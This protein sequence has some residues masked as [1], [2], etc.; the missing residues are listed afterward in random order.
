[1]R[2]AM[3]WILLFGVGAGEVAKPLWLIVGASD[4]SP[5]GIA[6]K[7]K[8]AAKGRAAGL[9]FDARDCGDP[10]AVYGWAVELAESESAAHEAL[11]R[12]RAGIP[13]AYVKRCLVRP[14]SLLSV[15]QAAVDGSI[16]GVP[17]DVVNWSDEQR[18]SAAAAVTVGRVVVVVR[19]YVSYPNDEMEGRRERLVVVGPDSRSTTLLDPCSGAGSVG[20]RGERV[21]FHCATEQAADQDL[22]TTYVFDVAGK[23][24]AAIPRCG[25]PHW[26]NDR[27]VECAAESIGS[28]GL[29]SRRA[30]RM[31]LP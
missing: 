28:D 25:N 21:V 16:A 20:A 4:A 7:A 23:R 22:H 11:A 13:N 15:R 12:A 9:V 14:G 3:L 1:M 2:V 18:L 8:A 10:K 19:Y 27:T 5:T 29:V 26:V 24:L 17:D 30:K 31:H 6:R